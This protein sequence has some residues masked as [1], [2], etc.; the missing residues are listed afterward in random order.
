MQE[1]T[2]VWRE[3]REGIRRIVQ[4]TGV[5]KKKAE[6]G[7]IEEFLSLLDARQLIYEQLDRLREETGITAWTITPEHGSQ[8][9]KAYS[10]EITAALEQLIQD[11]QMM[12]KALD[13]QKITL[14]E[15]LEEVRQSRQAQKRY[16]GSGHAG[17]FIDSKG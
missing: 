9:V 1:A 3:A 7:Q 10:R 5:M 15:D 14:Q 16:G 13:A 2:A 6:E 12:K 4:I 8:A 17:I 11:D